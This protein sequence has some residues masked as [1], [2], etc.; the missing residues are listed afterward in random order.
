[1]DHTLALP[2]AN[3]AEVAAQAREVDLTIGRDQDVAGFDAPEDGIVM[4]QEETLGLQTLGPC[5]LLAD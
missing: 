2:V 4:G 1:M 5:T 3:H